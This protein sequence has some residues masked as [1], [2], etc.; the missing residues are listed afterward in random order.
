MSKP[1]HITHNNIEK[2]TFHIS[3][4]F[5]SSQEWDSISLL[6]T[7]PNS[8]YK[9]I[10]T[11][12][13]SGINIDSY[14]LRSLSSIIHSNRN[15]KIFKLD[16]NYLSE[17]IEDFDM[18]CESI[19]N[20]SINQVYLNNNKLNSTN[21]FAICKLLTSRGLV[22]LDLRWN[23]IGSEGAREILKNLSNNKSRNNFNSNFNLKELN[24]LGNNISQEILFEIN[25]KINL[26]KNLNFQEGDKKGSLI[27]QYDFMKT[28]NFRENFNNLK[29]FQNSNQDQDLE[30][31]PDQDHDYTEL[32]LKE[33][34]LTNEYKTRYE[35]QLQQTT[36][37]EKKLKELEVIL[38]NEKSS[39]ST[40][41]SSH[42]KELQIEREKN[43]QYEEIILKQKEDFMSKELEWKKLLSDTEKDISKL[44]QEKHE[45]TIDNDILKEEKK[46]LSESYEEKLKSL[47]E[48]YEKKNFTL[49]SGYDSIK[50]ENESLRRNFFEEK[51]I[52]SKEF[53][54]K[55]KIQQ[56][57]NLTLKSTNDQ[58]EKEI[59]IIKREFHEY[60]MNKEFEIKERESRFAEEEN[61]KI[62]NIVKQ[63]ESR[64]K[65]FENFKNKLSEKNQKLIQEI[66]NLRKSLIDESIEYERSIQELK[67]EKSDIL[68]NY[69]LLLSSVNK[70]NS[71][72]A[73]KEGI[74]NVRNEKFKF[75]KFF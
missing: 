67:N 29:I 13:L 69:N 58:L 59:F 20:S 74:I 7:K 64:F 37:L 61:R 72:L 9:Y 68:K 12:H 56:D 46:L 44:I 17:Y 28:N 23:E 18:L 40:I 38:T 27:L 30:P 4:K 32:L 43:L 33:K 24:L 52:L 6:L 10:T 34:Q 70:M 55:L 45:I 50:I 19:V 66:E 54:R 25:E 75:L 15:F 53:D 16:W 36:T 14:G 62:E 41:K 2:E 49:Q 8:Q 21:V 73:L 35:S 42:T 60:K 47:Q 31:D 51:K 22:I 57:L 1:N 71:D 65:S 48:M 39:L 3:N 5:I 26:Y 11:I 63:Y